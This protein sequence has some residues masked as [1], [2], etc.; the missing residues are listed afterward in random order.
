MILLPIERPGWLYIFFFLEELALSR[1][2][3]YIFVNLVSYVL[4]DSMQ[5]RSCTELS[6]EIR[7]FKHHLT[8]DI[9]YLGQG[10]FTILKQ[11]THLLNTKHVSPS[12][13]VLV[14]DSVLHGNLEFR[15]IP[16]DPS[17][18]R[19]QTRVKWLP[20]LQCTNRQM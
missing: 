11:L 10:I 1:Y 19:K 16:T 12:C 8:F 15:Y 7:Y 18:E 14:E 3:Y 17:T 5:D 9:L 4:Y 2:M 6:D 20:W 13:V